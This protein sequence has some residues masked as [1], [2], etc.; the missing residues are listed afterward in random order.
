MV[1]VWYPARS[2]LRPA[3]TVGGRIPNRRRLI[4][5]PGFILTHLKYVTTNAVPGAPVAG[6][7]TS[8][9][10]LIFSHGRGGFRQHNT[11]QV[12]ELVSHGYIV[13]TIDH[14]YAASAVRFP[15]ERLATFDGR[16][17][18]PEHPGHARFLDGV[19]PFLA[20]DAIFTL[21]RLAALNEA[22][23]NGLLT[24][25]LDMQRAGIFGS[26]LGGIVSAEACLL[27]P[28]LQACLVQD[29]FMPADVVEAG[30]QQ[31]T[32]WFS[33]DRGTM[34]LEGWT[35]EDIDETE[36]TIRTTFENSHADRYLVLVPGMFHNEFSDAALLA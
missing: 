8:Y 26:S 22:D 15:D 25:R 28:R 10:L 4:N 7:Q 33:R 6:A 24:G 11:L 30:L 29:V 35:Q 19:I 21:N 20:Q 17:F 27:E 2:V 32:L 12:E 18:D 34:Q 9:P 16:M 23:P 14:P 13:A 1:Q 3:R 31:P 5:L 36:S